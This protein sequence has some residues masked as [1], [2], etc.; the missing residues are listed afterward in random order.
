MGETVNQRT[1]SIEG[2]TKKYE[3]RG[4]CHAHYMQWRRHGDPLQ[5]ALDPDLNP[6]QRFEQKYRLNPKTGCWEWFAYRNPKGYGQFGF[7]GRMQPAHRVAY[8]LLVG[9]I[10]EGLEVDHLCHN[11]SCVNPEHLEAVT[12]RVNNHRRIR[13]W[14][15]V[16][17]RY[18]SYDR[19]AYQVR[20]QRD[21]QLVFSCRVPTLA[22]AVLELRR[23]QRLFPTP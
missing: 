23:A 13:S 17:I 18:I 8:K 15:K 6:I 1:C 16:G 10:P 22:E 9:E 4:W 2:C 11:T 12:A 5:K 21:G 7:E 14:G 3:A 19:T 20:I